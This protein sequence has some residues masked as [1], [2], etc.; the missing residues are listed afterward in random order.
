MNTLIDMETRFPETSAGSTSSCLARH[1]E[2]RGIAANAVP[3]AMPFGSSSRCSSR[4]L[5]NESSGDVLF[6]EGFRE[7][8]LLGSALHQRDDATSSMIDV[9]HLDEM[10]RCRFDRVSLAASLIVERCRNRGCC[11][12][13]RSPA[14]SCF[15]SGGCWRHRCSPHSSMYASG[16]GTGRAEGVHE[17]VPIHVGDVLSLPAAVSK[18]IPAID[19]LSTRPRLRALPS[20]A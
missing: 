19:T 1:F 14:T 6:A 9:I 5:L 8:V 15:P 4:A 3:L 17:Q 7:G 12:A 2:C 13:P 11:S 10:P 18:K 20:P 16:N